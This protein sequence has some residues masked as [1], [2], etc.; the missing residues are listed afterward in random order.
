MTTMYAT[1]ISTFI[2]SLIS[3]F[4]NDKK[5]RALAIFWM[6]IVV[7]ILIVFSGFRTGLIGDTEMY[8]HSYR[9]YAS[10]NSLAKFDRDPGFVILNLILIQFSSNPQTLVVI[11]SLIVNLVNMIVF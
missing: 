9:L 11:T 2:L 6:L 5:Y 3:R 1:L 7:T 4:A 8:M 10:D